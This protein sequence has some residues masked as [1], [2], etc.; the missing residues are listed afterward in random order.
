MYGIGSFAQ[1]PRTVTGTTPRTHERDV[2]ADAEI[3]GFDDQT[4]TWQRPTGFTRDPYAHPEWAAGI[5]SGARAALLSMRM[6]ADDTYVGALHAPPGSIVA[7]R[8]DA[9]YLTGPQAWPYHGQPGDYLYKGHLTGPVP[10][11]AMEEELL[12]LRDAG[13]AALHQTAPGGAA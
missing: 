10:A 6:R 8:T 12:A 1:R 3:I 11:P 7:F 4:I 5:W 9:V 2:P 13:R